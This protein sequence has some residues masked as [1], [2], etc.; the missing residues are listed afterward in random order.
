MSSA[1]NAAGIAQQPRLTLQ[2]ADERRQV[3]L[4]KRALDLPH[5]E[6]RPQ[7][8]RCDLRKVRSVGSI[9]ALDERQPVR[10]SVDVLAELGIDRDGSFQQE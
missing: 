5:D 3:A 2:Q 10:E 9:E 6:Y 7:A 1:W 8:E 4:L